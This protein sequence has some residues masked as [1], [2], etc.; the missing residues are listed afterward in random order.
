MADENAKPRTRRKKPMNF[1]NTVTALCA[2][3]NSLKSWWVDK[4]INT[5]FIKE[6]RLMKERGEKVL[7]LIPLNLDEYF[8][9]G[10]GRAGR[11]KTFGFAWRRISAA[12]SETT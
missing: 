6:Q 5:A 7:A 8:S 4:E 9:A 11:R 2:S 12:G 10:N 3:K 1:V